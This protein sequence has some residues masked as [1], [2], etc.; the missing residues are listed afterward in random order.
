[1]A[2]NEIPERPDLS[3]LP[4]ASE[5]KKNREG[6]QAALQNIPNVVGVITNLPP[7]FVNYMPY[8]RVTTLYLQYLE[9]LEAEVR[10]YK[11]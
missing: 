8:E 4:P 5:M 11:P 2:N 6:T 1:M 3:N 7:E 9:R 10:E